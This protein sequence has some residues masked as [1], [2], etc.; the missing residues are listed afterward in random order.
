MTGQSDE[1]IEFCV[2]LSLDDISSDA[3]DHARLSL[4]N[5]IGVTLG[6]QEDEATQIATRQAEFLGGNPQA[7]IF[8]TPQMTSV[9][10]AGLINGISSHVLDFDDTHLPTVYHPTAPLMAS[11]VPL[12]EYL[13]VSGEKFLCAWT[14]GLEGGIRLACALGRPHY[15]HGWHVTSTAGYVAAALACSI[16]L[17]L[18]TTR[19]RHAVGIAATQSSG[20]RQQFGA[21]TKSF[22]A[23]MAGSGGLLAA[24]L[25]SDGYT[26]NNDSVSGRRGL[27]SVMSPDPDP[28]ALTSGLGENWV[29]LENCL[30]PYASGVVTHPL[31]DAGRLLGHVHEVDA[32]DITGLTLQVNPLVMELTNIENPSTGLEAKFSVRHC[33]AV[34]FLDNG[35]GPAQFSNERVA[36]GDIVSLR[37]RISVEGGDLPHMHARVHVNLTD[38]NQFEIEVHDA[39]GTMARP[40]TTIEVRKKY[41]SLANP[42]IGEIRARSIHDAVFEIEERSFNDLVP[43]DLN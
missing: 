7:H 25:A 20:H 5:A 9:D 37:D 27:L 19:T 1:L 33:F 11:V 15:D 17:G 26:A 38:G 35:G 24:L 12:A 31:I 16:L 3:R 40:L 21:M 30:K 2:A 22:H 18:D 8:G 34:G 29:L 39:R 41:F 32:E 36:A 6:G 13:D 43:V 23:G 10:R 28:S 42:A 14:V 4:L